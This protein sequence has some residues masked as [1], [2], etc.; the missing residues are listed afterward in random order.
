MRRKGLGGMGGG[1][2]KSF[3]MEGTVR[4]KALRDGEWGQRAE[5]PELG[6][7]GA[8]LPGRLC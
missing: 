8:A 7:G 5:R 2:G 6:P 4:R 1:A 3:H